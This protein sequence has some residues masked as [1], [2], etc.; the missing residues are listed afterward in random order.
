MKG[1]VRKLPIVVMANPSLSQ[2]EI[3][4]GLQT[5]KESAVEPDTPNSKT[6]R[7]AFANS[8]DSETL[9]AQ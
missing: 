1:G 9:L 7:L 3:Q 4:A 8:P 2:V 6:A 5:A